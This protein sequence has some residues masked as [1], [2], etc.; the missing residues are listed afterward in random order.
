M[1]ILGGLEGSF[2]FDP[3]GSI[4]VMAMRNEMI[5]GRNVFVLPMCVLAP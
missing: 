2:W 1:R 3:R 4:N 5:D